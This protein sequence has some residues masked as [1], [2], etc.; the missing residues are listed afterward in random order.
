MTNVCDD[1]TTRERAAM[2]NVDEVRAMTR[3]MQR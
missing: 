1:P 3:G 2:T